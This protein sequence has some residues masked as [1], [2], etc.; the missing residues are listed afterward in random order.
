MRRG[1]HNVLIHISHMFPGRAHWTKLTREKLV[2]EDP[3][4]F[5]NHED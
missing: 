1:A 5:F 3:I 2:E 4:R